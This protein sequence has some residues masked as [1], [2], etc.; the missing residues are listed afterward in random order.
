MT[1]RHLRIFTEVCR[2]ESITLAGENLNMAQPAVSSAIKELESYYGVRLFERMNRKIYITNAGECLF[3]Y[4]NSILNQFEE[5]KDVIG[6]IAAATRIRIGSNISFGTSYLPNLLSAFRKEHPEVPIYTMIQNSSRIEEALLHNELD[7]AIVDN[8]ATSPNFY[9]RLL[10]KDQMTAVCTPDFPYLSDMLESINS[11]SN[12][13]GSTPASSQYEVTLG[14]LSKIPLLLRE[15]GS[16]LRDTI[17]RAF[18][19]AELRPVI[20]V[21][22]ISTQALI[23]FCLNGQGL[24]ILPSAIAKKYLTAHQ[25]L[26]FKIIDADFSRIYYL[27]YHKSKFLTKSMR[28]FLDQLSEPFS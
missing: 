27:I 23:E 11:S 20:A 17:E 24:L 2:M 26:E 1:I 12:E 7:L 16:G 9:S 22:S 28:Y 18:Q 8:L 3:N 25:L 10:M 6:D 4:A 5:A 14:T 19:Q 13:I 15:T 21:E